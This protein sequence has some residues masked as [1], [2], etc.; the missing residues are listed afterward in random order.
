MS[1]GVAWRVVVVAGASSASGR[2][3][4]AA[5][6][7]AGARVVAVGS[8]AARLGEV[9]AARREVCDLRDFGAVLELAGRIRGEEGAIDGLVHL[10]GGWRGGN[11]LAGQTDE[12]WDFLHERI[13]T[14]LRNT[15]RA[16]A[17]DLAA[18]DAGRLAIVSST[19][20]Q[21]P[22]PGGANYA[23]AKLAAETWVRAVDRGFS[24]SG[25]AA[26]STIFVVSTLNGREGQLA[27]A[28]VDLWSHLPP[29]RHPLE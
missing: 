21:R 6:T 15:T 5:L 23:T 1:A 20:A 19:A 10:V 22:Y 7:A 25:S 14:T 18:S 17:D 13:L 27:D 24:K 28:V 3:V 12:D 9:D 2:A 29:Q 16:F 11:G 8:D 4:A 26:R